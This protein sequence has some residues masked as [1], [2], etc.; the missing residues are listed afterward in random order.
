MS[1]LNDIALIARTIVFGDTRAFGRL[2]EKYQSTIRRFFMHQTGG[3][4]ALTDDLA[5]ET[6][7]RAYQN[8]AKFKNLAGFST[9]LHSIAYNVLY[10][11]F[12]SAH[13]LEEIAADMAEKQITTSKSSDSQHDIHVAM[14]QL[15]QNERVCIT[16][17]Y[18]EDMSLERI[19]QITE[20]P[21][22][23]IKSHLSRGKQKLAIWLNK[24]GYGKE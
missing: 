18:L 12:R 2:V 10:D 24:N 11:Y 15:N 1:Q 8:I 7:I 6:F 16:L 19:N 3:N 17:F 22:G 4:T 23:T 20:M 9:W 13:P 21:I 14:K 5:Q